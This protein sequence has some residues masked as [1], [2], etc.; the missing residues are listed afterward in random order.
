MKS[1]F[2]RTKQAH[3]GMMEKHQAVLQQRDDMRLQM[4]EAFTVKEA[5]RPE[6][7]L[8]SSLSLCC[9]YRNTGILICSKSYLVCLLFDGRCLQMFKVLASVFR[10]SV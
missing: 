5:V 8:L 4:E 3:T 6:A 1:L 2:K 9:Y 7:D 10:P